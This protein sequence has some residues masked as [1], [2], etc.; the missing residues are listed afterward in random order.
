[1]A[2]ADG[3]IRDVAGRQRP[4]IDDVLVPPFVAH[5]QLYDVVAEIAACEDARAALGKGLDKGRIPVEVWVRQ[6]RAV[7]REEFLK[8]A[9]VRKLGAGLGLDQ[10]QHWTE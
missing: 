8:R 1:M 3:V 10:G 9:I 2:Q 4:N 6:M 7:S 5:K